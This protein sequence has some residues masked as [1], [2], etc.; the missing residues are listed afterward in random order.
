MSLG[1]GDE[2]KAAFDAIVALAPAIA[3]GKDAAGRKRL[4]AA[5]LEIGAFDR[6]AALLVADAERAEGQARVDLLRQAATIHAEKAGDAARAAD[7]LERASKE[8]P[9]DRALLLDLCDAYSAAGRAEEAITTLE[10]VVESFGGKRAKE[11]GEIHRRLAGAF[12]A[13]G[14]R[15]RALEELDKAFRIEPG[16]IAILKQLGELALEAGDFKKADQMFRALLLQRLDDKSPVTKA[17]V[18]CRLGDLQRAQG[19]PSKAKQFY[20]RAL[21]ADKDLEE[22]KAGLAAC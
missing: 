18:F 3:E 10:K 6:I 9:D 1:R 14:D 4:D 2:A 11:L 20:E 21:A 13:K 17:Q 12:V 8:R 5:F 15:T 22:A 19:E 16:N 7:L